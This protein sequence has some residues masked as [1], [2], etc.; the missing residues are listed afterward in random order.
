MTVGIRAPCDLCCSR[1]VP[2]RYS[3]ETCF[4]SCSFDMLEICQILLVS[5]SFC[6]LGYC[7]LRIV[8]M[9]RASL[10]QLAEWAAIA[11]EG[12]VRLNGSWLDEAVCAWSLLSWNSAHR[13]PPGER[14]TVVPCRAILPNGLVRA[15][16]VSWGALLAASPPPTPL[17]F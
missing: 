13:P 1:R 10:A 9:A 11:L 17:R 7:G 12:C 16:G 6:G 5:L 8:L 15:V 4:S 14:G 3:I 2:L